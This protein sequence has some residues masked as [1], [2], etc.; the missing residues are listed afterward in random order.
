MRGVEEWSPQY[1]IFLGEL[2]ISFLWKP[3]LDSP[4][5]NA[6]RPNFNV[7][8]PCGI[9]RPRKSLLHP[10][11]AFTPSCQGL[12]VWC[13]TLQVKT[14]SESALPLRNPQTEHETLDVLSKCP[15]NTILIEKGLY[16]LYR[17]GFRGDLSQ[18]H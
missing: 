6:S 15:Y 5:F 1:A 13:A 14:F 18:A 7:R 10:A 2:H 17:R 3:G 16:E 9:A 8:Q 11:K 12:S 4:I